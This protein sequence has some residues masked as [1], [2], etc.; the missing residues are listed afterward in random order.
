MIDILHAV[1]RV[2]PG[3]PAAIAGGV[4]LFLLAASVAFFL[5]RGSGTITRV[6]FFPRTGSTTFL[7]ESRQLPNYHDLERDV[8]ALAQEEILG[9]VR[10]DA[11][12]LMQRD[13]SVDSLFVRGGVAYLDLSADLVLD[14]TASGAQLETIRRAIRFNF[15]GIHDVFITIGRQ[16]PR[17]GSPPGNNR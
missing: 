12:P 14:G 1:R 17:F 3:R 6:L 11:D 5:F 8:R 7:A 2:R 9:P 10:N 16:V 4:F 13:E 15:P